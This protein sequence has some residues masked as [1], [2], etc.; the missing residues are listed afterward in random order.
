MTTWLR[1]RTAATGFGALI[2]SALASPAF[3]QDSATGIN[4]TDTAWMIVA[5]AFV[6]MMTVPGLALFYAGMVRK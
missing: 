1:N 6:L 5:T 2:L 3:A 4:P